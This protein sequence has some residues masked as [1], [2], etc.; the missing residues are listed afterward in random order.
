VS[1]PVIL[2][3]TR[4]FSS[5]KLDLNQ[6]LKNAGYQVVIGD[7]SHDLNS[8]APVLTNAVAWIAGVAPIEEQHLAV[9]ANLKIIAR[10]GVGFEAV[11]LIAAEKKNIVV[12]NTPGANSLAV[13]EHSLALL[14]ASARNVA[15]SYKNV[16]ENNW[17][18]ARGRQISGSKIG[19]IGF[20][21]I[22]KLV[23]EKLQA[24]AAEVFVSDPY[25]KPEEIT[26]VGAKTAALSEIAQFCDFVLLQAPGGQLL[27]DQTWIS[28]AL[29]G[30]IIVN[31][32]RADLVDETAI[33]DGLLSGQLDFYAA[34]ALVDEI[35]SPLLVEDLSEKV[36]VT[37][38][39][40]GQT[41]AAVDQMGAMA[42][43]N[44]LAVLAGKDPVNP[45]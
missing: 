45:V 43:A 35:N 12:T 33:A 9:A 7:F 20:G 6:E 44:V 27:I 10:Y 24:L 31:T 18:T 42:V 14:F 3:T 8:I 37:A 39:I 22:G 26:K 16:R 30:Q 40:A 32:A 15:A 28:Q 11:D 1:Q 4:S 21:R 5:G 23:V 38:H 29:T 36:L 41:T 34:D 13:A 2:V 25:V 19:I 17:I